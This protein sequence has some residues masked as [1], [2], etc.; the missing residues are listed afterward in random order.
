MC[1]CGSRLLNGTCSPLQV[2][3]SQG[4]SATPEVDY[5][6]NVLLNNQ[7]ADVA[8]GA[9]EMVGNLYSQTFESQH[10]FIRSVSTYFVENVAAEYILLQAQ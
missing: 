5:L 10:E 8:A 6:W 3:P 9:Q 1:V 2:S 4:L 7:N